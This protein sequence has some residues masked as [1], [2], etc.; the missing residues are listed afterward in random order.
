MTPIEPQTSRRLVER[1]PL[2]VALILSLLIHLSLY[3]T[4]RLGR[5]F[6]W[7]DHQSSWL[8]RLTERIL[9]SP[10]R[11]KAVTRPRAAEETARREIPLTFVEV[12]PAT[13]TEEA[14]KDAKYYSSSNSKAA[15]A[16]PTVDTEVPK[17][18]GNQDKVVRLVDNDRPNPVPLQPDNLPPPQEEP[19]PKPKGGEVPGDLAMAKKRDPAPPSDGQVEIGLGPSPTVPKKRPRY[20]SEAKAQKQPMLAGEKMRQDGGMT[21]RGALSLDAKAT[22]FGA[23]DAALIAAVEQAWYN[24]L[25]E[26]LGTLRTGKV[27]IE[28]RLTYEGKVVKLKITENNVGEILGQ[29]C[30][31]AI[32]LPAPYGVWPPDMRRAI[33]GNFRDVKFTFYYY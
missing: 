26:H 4:W 32:T 3:G 20:V 27:V 7:W 31:N 25:D 18:D 10:A 13:A 14:P 29:Y 24:L 21:R 5:Q 6:H 1:N 16:D 22:P 23:Y 33:G 28:F 11:P 9:H 30:Y 12:D 2:A 19:P 8:L 15:N 17:V